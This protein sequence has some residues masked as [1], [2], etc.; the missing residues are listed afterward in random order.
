MKTLFTVLCIIMSIKTHHRLL[1]RTHHQPSKETKKKKGGDNMMW[2]VLPPIAIS[3][4]IFIYRGEKW[5][6]H[7]YIY[8]LQ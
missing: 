2:H 7:N 8:L 4:N 6:N 1:R 3:F 5:K